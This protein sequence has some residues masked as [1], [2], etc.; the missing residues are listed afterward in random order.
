MTEEWYDKFKKLIEE[1]DKCN[2]GNCKTCELS[3]GQFWTDY[4]CYDI[5]GLLEEI[6]SRM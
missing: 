3:K 1:F 4:N 2:G 6:S 5:C